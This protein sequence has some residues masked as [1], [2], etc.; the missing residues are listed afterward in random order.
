M[1]FHKRLCAHC[2]VK[3]DSKLMIKHSR[4]DCA[5]SSFIIKILEFVSGTGCKNNNICRV[6]LVKRLKRKDYWMKTLMT[7]YPYAQNERARERYSVAPVWKLIFFLYLELSNNLLQI[8]TIMII[9]KLTL[10]RTFLQTFIT[11]FRM[12]LTTLSI[13]FE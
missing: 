2:K 8:E 7:I 6:E 13:K 12:T 9:W 5:R 11:S 4:N 3:S 1:P 10:W